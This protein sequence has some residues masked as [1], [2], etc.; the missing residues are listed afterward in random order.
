MD[1]YVKSKIEATNIYAFILLC[2]LYP[3]F[4]FCSK[5]CYKD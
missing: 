1:A 3:Y 2:N 4:S 5:I